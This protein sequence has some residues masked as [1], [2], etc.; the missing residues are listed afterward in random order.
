[1]CGQAGETV[2]RRAMQ[3][4]SLFLMGTSASPA[5]IPHP[6]NA[7]FDPVHSPDAVTS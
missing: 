4:D 7:S 2:T 1:V 5:G 6:V 3:Q